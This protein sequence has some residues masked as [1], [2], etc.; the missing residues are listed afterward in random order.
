M[1]PKS[2]YVYIVDD[3]RSVRRSLSVLLELEGFKVEVFSSAEDCLKKK[4]LK[5][6]GCLIS[7]IR[8]PGLSGLEFQEICLQRGITI[9]MVIITGH[10]DV[11]MTVEAMK[12][13]AIDFLQKPYDTEKLVQAVKQAIEKDLRQLQ[14]E[15]YIKRLMKCVETLSER[16]YQVFKKVTA[17]FLN[18]QIARKL[19]ISEKTVKFHRAS[20]MRKMK[21]SSVA[22]LVH[23]AESIPFNINK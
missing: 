13:G 21:A 22:Q 17:G 14:K 7:D 2:S 20:V 18:K 10:G 19:L 4:S 16:E 3:D 12:K 6:P 9:P 8:M 15:R 11:P 1:S 5:R 23:L